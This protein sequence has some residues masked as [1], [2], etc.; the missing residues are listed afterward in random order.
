M[1]KSPR[2]RLENDYEEKHN[3][4]RKSWSAVGVIFLILAAL[5]SSALVIGMGL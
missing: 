1:I 5:L 4:A 2:E 3:S